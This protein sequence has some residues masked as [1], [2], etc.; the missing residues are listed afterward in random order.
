[1]TKLP[2]TEWFSVYIRNPEKR[3]WQFWKPQW[4]FSPEYKEYI[5]ST[6]NVM[7][8]FEYLEIKK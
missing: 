5:L 7:N 3:W 1:M 4:I 2:N 6:N 8:D